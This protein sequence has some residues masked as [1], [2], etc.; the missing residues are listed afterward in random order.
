M[1][2]RHPVGHAAAAVVAGDG[3]AV[4]AER[5]HRLDQVDARAPASSARRGRASGPAGRTPRTRAGPRRRRCTASASSG[6]RAV[7]HE[8]RLRVA[9]QQEHRRPA[10]ADPGED[11]PP[12]GR[13]LVLR[14]AVEHARLLRP[15]RGR[16]RRN[17]ARV[18]PLSRPSMT[19][20]GEEGEQFAVDLGGV[21][22][23]HHVRSAVDLDVACGG[24][25][26][27]QPAPLPV[28]RQ[29]AVGG[30]VQDQ[31]RYVDLV[32][33]GGEVVEPAEHA[34]PRRVRGRL[35]PRGPECAGRLLA[36]PLAEV[37]V[38]V[39]E[40][41]DQ[42]GQPR[43]P[44]VEDGLL[45]AGDARLVDAGGVV[46]GLH[47]RWSEALDEHCAPQ[48]LRAVPANV[49]GQ[50]AGAEGEA[51]HG[52]VAQVEGGQHGVEVGGKGVEVVADARPARS[53]EPAPVV[54]DHSV[55]GGEQRR[56]AGAPRTGRRTASR[57]AARPRARCPGPRSRYRSRRCSPDRR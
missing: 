57:P 10:A 39:E 19:G 2:E 55:P 28:D 4:V 29:D 52:D 46:G 37:L 8:V 56:A 23:A 31:R 33:V 30:A 21:R 34:G 11:G 48:P 20:V 53:P 42:P 32:D 22:H 49:A 24:Q 50:L 47:E 44:V 35:G 18:T 51:D 15:C 6:G 45:D 38:E 27:V 13:H 14:E 25:G 40:V 54:V 12:P 36:D 7:P 41:R 26:S 5:G 1:V 17:D 43:V 9:V 3:E 16:S